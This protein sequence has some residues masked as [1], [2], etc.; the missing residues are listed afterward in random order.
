MRCISNTIAENVR[1]VTSDLHTAAR[2]A[3][4]NAQDVVL[5]AV[6]K[7][8]PT[9]AI[10]AGYQAGLRHFGENYVQEA[11]RKIDALA[12]LDAQWHFIGPLQSNKTRSVA[13]RFDWVHS[14]DR[15]KIAQRLSEQREAAEPLNVCIQLNVDADPNKSGVNAAAAEDLLGEMLLLPKLRIR[16]LMT[17]LSAQT[18]PIQGF[19]EL[20]HQ[21]ARLRPLAGPHWDCLSMGMS[22]DFTQA[23]AAGATHVRVGTAIFGERPNA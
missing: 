17:I 5:I 11:E 22:A 6:S 18:P 20:Q 12:D 23:I 4:R 3:G 1:Q 7:R 19:S 9:D 13:T 16:G 2:Q 10:R 21:F 14:I 15:L 8:H